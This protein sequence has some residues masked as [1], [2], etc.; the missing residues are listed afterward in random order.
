M[1]YSSL[2]AVQSWFAYHTVDYKTDLID[3]RTINQI[4]KSVCFF[5][6][7]IALGLLE[8]ESG[9]L[10]LKGRGDVNLDPKKKYSIPNAFIR[11]VNERDEYS[12]VY[13]GMESSRERE[14]Y[15]K[16]ILS[17]DHIKPR[18]RM[19]RQAVE[20][21]ATACIFCNMEKSKRTPEEFG[22]IPSF[23]APEYIYRDQM[24]L[25]SDY[26]L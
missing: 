3:K 6:D 8:N 2:H 1:N 12:C 5:D 16:K 23:L 22:L 9:L 13:C 10:T 4:A 14:M 17:I 24:I 21:L 15:K 25:R 7:A 20:D 26:G 19:P 11:F 18:C